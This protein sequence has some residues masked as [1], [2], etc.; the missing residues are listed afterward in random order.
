MACISEQTPVSQEQL[1]AKLKRLAGEI[2]SDLS[3]VDAAQGKE[4]LSDFV[5]ELFLAA[6]DQRRREERRRKQ[7]E[8]I[9]EAK[10][11][12]VHFGRTAKPVPENFD[13]LHQA[14]RE[15]RVSLQQAASACGMA[16]GTFYSAVMRKEQNA[17]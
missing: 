1:Q 15:G 2:I 9:A 14:W 5:S 3:A 4:L 11:K 10:A 12:G 13:E 16:R 17:G 7:A 6:A 8:G